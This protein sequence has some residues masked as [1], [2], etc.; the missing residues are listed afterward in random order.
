[1]RFQDLLQAFLLNSTSTGRISKRPIII[2]KESTNLDRGENAE[3]LP[4]GPTISKPGPMLLM[5]ATTAV[6]EVPKV[7]LSTAT[8]RV[9]S[10]VMSM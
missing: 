6:K 8:A 3:K 7:K 1:M 2:H 9:P 5:H 4:M 10:R